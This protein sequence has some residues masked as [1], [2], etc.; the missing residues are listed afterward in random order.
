MAE[1]K[2][3][4][5]LSNKVDKYLNSDA[6]SAIEDVLSELSTEMVDPTEKVVDVLN[7]G[8]RVG[9]KSDQ[10]WAIV[11]EYLGGMAYLFTKSSPEEVL[12]R[13]ETRYNAAMSGASS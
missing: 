6:G 11:S 8:Y 3:N 4:H 12:K 7:A 1:I 5:E 2:V 13:L 9:Q 10:A